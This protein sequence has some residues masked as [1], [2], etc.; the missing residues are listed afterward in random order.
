[1]LSEQYIF[2]DPKGDKRNTLVYLTVEVNFWELK[3]HFFMR[4]SH[5]VFRPIQA[6]GFF[7]R[8]FSFVSLDFV[9]G[10]VFSLRVSGIVFSF[11]DEIH[12]T[13]KFTTGRKFRFPLSL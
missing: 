11:Y 12:K 9:S 8:F 6:G 5:V 13:L 7:V 3:S 2:I 10:A 1:M 4:Y